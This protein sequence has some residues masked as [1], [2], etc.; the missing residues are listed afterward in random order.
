MSAIRWAG[1]IAVL[2][3]AA[4]LLPAST[5]GAANTMEGA[6][7]FSGSLKFDPPL[8]NELREFSYRDWASGTC[9]GT[10]N[11]VPQQDA[12]A[13]IRASGSGTGSCLAGRT[14]SS[15]TLT[16]TRGT[17]READD[18]KIRF[19]TNLAGVFTQYTGTFHG[20][21]SGDGTGLVNLLP[22]ESGLAE[23]EAG[24]LDFLR[25]DLVARTITPLVG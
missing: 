12:P 15:G 20:A 17:K 6:C 4:A 1:L 19:S 21:I 9:T 24:A 25:Y 5:A 3:M 16:F 8:G 7:T 18:V 14:T 11:G 2:G 10:L 13:V 23:C 22:G